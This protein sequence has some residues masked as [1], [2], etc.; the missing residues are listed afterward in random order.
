MPGLNKLYLNKLYAI[1]DGQN[2][3]FTA[4]QAK[5][6]GYSRRMQIYHVSNDDWEKVRRGIFRF[7]L[8][9]PDE[10]PDFMPWY[11]WSCNSDG[12]PQAVFSHDS[13]L[14][15]YS[16]GTWRSKKIHLTVPPNFRRR[17]VP[18]VLQLHHAKLTA[19]DIRKEHFV[20]ATTPL[21]TF[22]DLLDTHLSLDFIQEALSDAL[23][24]Q[25]I[26]IQD[27]ED[28]NLDTEQKKQ[29]SDMLKRINN[30][31]KKIFKPIRFSKSA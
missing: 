27:I 23:D 16:I 25:L 11:L 18:A 2:G 26:H 5:Q 24:R 22:I 1:A 17:V 31:R 30:E 4:Q 9:P 3:Y 10:H 12:Q 28:A 29:F 8:Y 20:L 6:A 19:H 7:R 13:A 14:A 21:K 15:I